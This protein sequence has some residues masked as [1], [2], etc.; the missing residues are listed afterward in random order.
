MES[1]NVKQLVELEKVA[2]DTQAHL[3]QASKGIAKIYPS[4][5]ISLAKTKIEEAMMWLEKYQ[6]RLSIEL[7]RKTCK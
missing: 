1:L 3:Q 2:A 7:A 5:E 6:G 4:R